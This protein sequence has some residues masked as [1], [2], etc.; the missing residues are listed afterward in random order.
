MGCQE[1]YFRSVRWQN[2]NDNKILSFRVDTF[3]NKN[4]D[5]DMELKNLCYYVNT[6]YIHM[7]STT[8]LY[9]QDSAISSALN[10]CFFCILLY[11]KRK[12]SN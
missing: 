10:F 5:H 4:I 1:N 9:S 6:G 3:E 12:T 11:S 2:I 7:K 8:S